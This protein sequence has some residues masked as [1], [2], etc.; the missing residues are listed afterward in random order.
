MLVSTRTQLDERAYGST[1]SAPMEQEFFGN[2]LDT[3]LVVGAGSLRLCCYVPADAGCT[4]EVTTIDNKRL[5]AKLAGELYRTVRDQ[6]AAEQS[7]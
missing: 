5:R 7:R 6:G 2:D 1:N 4:G 3:T